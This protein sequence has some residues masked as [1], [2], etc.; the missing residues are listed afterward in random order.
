MTQGI[1]L[2]LKYIQLP[3][4]GFW[5]DQVQ[6]VVAK[7][8]ERLQLKIGPQKKIVDGISFTSQT[9]IEGLYQAYGS[10]YK[11]CR[12]SIPAS[13][14][15]Y[16]EMPHQISNHTHVVAKRVV[17]AL[18]ELGW[19][20]YHRGLKNKNGVNVPTS[21]RASG[22]LL[23][24][25]KKSGYVWRE[26]GPNIDD[27]IVL[28]GYDDVTKTKYACPFEDTKQI[29]LWRKNLQAYNKFIAKQAVC[30]SLDNAHLDYLI[31]RMAHRDFKP[32]FGFKSNQKKAR[33]FNFLHVQLR[34]IF[35][36]GSFGMGG[37]FYGG[38]WQFIPSDYRG[39][40]TI[41][42]QPTVEVDYS[43]LHPRLMYLQANLPIPEGDLYDLG[44]RYDGQ[45]YDKNVEPYRSK[46]KIIKTYINAV[47][48]DDRGHF[49]LNA[50]QI[51]K[52]GMKTSELAKLVAKKH[53][54][55]S[56]V[57]GKGV[58]LR[59]QFIDSQIAE[60]VMM[61]LLN[62]RIL[63]LPVHDSFICQERYLGELTQAMNEAYQ[64]VLGGVPSLKDP[65]VFKTDFEFA[66]YPSGEPDWTY[67][68][69]QHKDAVHGTFLS[70]YFSSQKNR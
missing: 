2:H 63:C 61:K 60:K 14:S 37:R 8:Y 48:N 56:S 3:L 43:E 22:E 10:R 62:K 32:D 38:W 17:D 52:L 57:K 67:M 33:V 4:T 13:K 54:I 65:E 51:K 16:G 15:G 29:T 69:H 66:L 20:D 31:G 41:N 23:D 53:P 9:V 19:V 49:K 45:P 44:L 39:Y 42:G 1:N 40:I 64:K 5:N 70:G 24:L 47:I 68:D 59:F 25:F 30:L 46:R 35:A 50:A 6:V 12:L 28:K 34:R 21:I 27:V 7:V 26:L 11:N 36:R 55:I 58:G 18:R